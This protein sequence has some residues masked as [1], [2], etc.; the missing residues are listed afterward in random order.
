MSERAVTK[1]NESMPTTGQAMSC[2]QEYAC[3]ASNVP[4]TMEVGLGESNEK[5]SHPDVVKLDFYLVPIPKYLWYNPDRPT[6]FDVL[7]N[8]LFGVAATCSE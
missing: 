7:T 5:A 3:T 4:S 8:V 1:E 6:N 2:T